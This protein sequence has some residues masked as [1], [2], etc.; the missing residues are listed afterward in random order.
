MVSGW[1][2]GKSDIAVMRELVDVMYTPLDPPVRFDTGVSVCYET[3]RF[4]LTYKAYTNP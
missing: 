4:L 1:G 3:S 2:W